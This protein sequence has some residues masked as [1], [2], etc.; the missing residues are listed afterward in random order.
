MERDK[1]EEVAIQLLRKASIFLPIDVKNA[2]K[3]AYETE[4]SE[5]G[6]TVLK[7]ILDNIAAAEQLNRPVCQ[8]TGIVSFFVKGRAIDYKVIESALIK[9]TIE[10]TK[11]IPLRP[12][13]VHPITRKNSGDNTG[14]RIPGIS[15]LYKDTDYLEITATIKGAGSEN[16]TALYMLPPGEGV[17]G[18]IRVVLESVVRAGGQPCPPVILNIGLGGTVDLTFKMAKLAMI[19]PLGVRHPEDDIAK[20]ESKILDLVN[21]TNVGPM[22][23]GGKTTALDVKIEYAYCHTAS[24][25]IAINFQCWA[26]RR[27]TARIHPDGS[28][29][30]ID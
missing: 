17:K 4:T 27:A 16:M 26:D 7:T 19:R 30:M 2:L 9:A 3:K 8:D 25:P 13:A 5:T 14:V 28:V 1:I 23:L 15:W 24:L 10:A 11:S 18:L 29:E 22:G 20:L 12:N 21:Q 6:R